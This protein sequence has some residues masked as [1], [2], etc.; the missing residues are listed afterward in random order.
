MSAKREPTP[1]G[2]RHLTVVPINAE[3]TDEDA[4]D[5]SSN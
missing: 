2:M 1:F 4:D 5:S 3:P